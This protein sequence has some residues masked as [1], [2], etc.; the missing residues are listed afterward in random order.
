MKTYFLI[1]NEVTQ[2]IQVMSD[3]LSLVGG[4][5][6]SSHEIEAG[7]PEELLQKLADHLNLRVVVLEPTNPCG[8]V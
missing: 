3:G 4:Y 1:V 2:P 5:L 7:S 8:A 6:G